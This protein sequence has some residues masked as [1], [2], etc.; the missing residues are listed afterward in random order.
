[1]DVGVYTVN[2]TVEGGI[3]MKESKMICSVCGEPKAEGV[4]ASRIAPVSSAYCRSCSEKGAEPYGVLVTRV[5]H[6]QSL[7]PEYKLSS[8]LLFVKR[9]T[10]EV[11]GITEEKFLEDVR[12]RINEMMGRTIK[13]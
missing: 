3:F 5:A 7:R 6:L 1:V 2:R 4:F 13:N 12:K 9:I 11:T 8:K 10:L